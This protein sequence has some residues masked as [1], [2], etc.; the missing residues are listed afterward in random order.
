LIDPAGPYLS[1]DPSHHGL[2]LH[3]VYHWPNGWDH[4]PQG[5][6]VPRGE[7][8]QW[9]DYHLR[10]VALYVRRLATGAPYYT[11]FGPAAAERG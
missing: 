11:F 9:G 5:A 4:V 8:S 3:S 2:L 1:T 7:S 10:E 6:K